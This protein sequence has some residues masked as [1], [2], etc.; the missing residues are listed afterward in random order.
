MQFDREVLE[1]MFAAIG[2]RAIDAGKLV[3]VAVY[4]GAALVLTLPGR[5]ATR[6]VDAVFAG[7]AGWLRR[8]VAEMNM[9]GQPIGSTMPSRDS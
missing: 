4:G 5:V 9:V 2:Q 6:D 7:D 3:E 1:R 8:T